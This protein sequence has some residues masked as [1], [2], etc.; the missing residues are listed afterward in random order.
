LTGGIVDVGALLQCFEGMHNGVA[1]DSILDKYCEVQRRMWH[2]IINPVSTANIRRLHLQD[3]DKA[4]ED[5][6]ILQLVRKSETDLD[7][8]R[9]L[10]SAGN[11]LVYDYTQ[12][13]RPAP[14]AGSAV[15]AKL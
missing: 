10:Q 14:K 2:D 8:S 11:E 6:E 7:L 1:D 13:Y 15:L 3:P 4:L 12:Y 9:E 5:D